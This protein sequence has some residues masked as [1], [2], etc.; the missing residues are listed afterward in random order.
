MNELLKSNSKAIVH[1]RQQ[2]KCRRLGLVFGAGI[3]KDLDFPNWSDLVKGIAEHEDVDGGV[4][5]KNDSKWSSSTSITQLLFQHFKSTRM[6]VLE[7]QYPSVAY[8]ERHVK[9]DWRE[10][11]HSVLYRSAL[12]SRFDK[13]K[14]HPYLINFIPLINGSEFSVNYN[15]DDTLEYMLSIQKWNQR[16][17]KGRP[18][19]SV[20][21]PHMQFRENTAVIY[22]PN[23]YL[24]GDKNLQQSDELVFSEESFSDQ[25]LESMSGKLST[26]LHM[27]TKK[28]CLLVGLSLQDNTLKH[29]LRQSSVI[30]PG[31]FHYFIRYTSNRDTLT[32][33]EKNA[34]FNSNF[35]VYNLITLFLD[36]EEISN[37]AELVS[38]DTEEF[39]N[40]ANIAGVDTN[41]NYYLVGTVGAG[42]STI[43]DH[44]GNLKLY[45]EWLEE[46]PHDLAKPFSQL[47]SDEKERVDE[48][49]NSQFFKKNLKLL[50]EKEGIHLID[51]TPLDPITFS[52]DDESMKLRAASMLKIIS[53]GNSNYQI[54][55]GH[56]LLVR[57]TPKELKNRL[58]SKRKTEWSEDD[59]ALLQERALK[60]YD[61]FG[62]KAI[63]NIGRTIPEIVK[64]V[65]RII[66]IE[67]YQPT[68][69]HLKLQE[70]AES[71]TP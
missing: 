7:A 67:D 30:S 35:E 33:N 12:E 64:E 40:L 47:T 2:Y 20:W 34:I 21:N 11:V 61:S 5:Y 51:R 15:F 39:V 42:K 19:Q 44:F 4:I 26:L 17:S 43:L 22:H 6:A 57:S 28:T 27:F 9:A 25:L 59:I 1:L 60:I 13:V 8:R 18:Y 70:V 24:P 46:R 56:V 49:V 54:S 32:D 14:N 48:W 66:H 10:I 58:L 29:L 65:A 38:M 31:N 62:L 53:P 69:L 37:L 55:L 41:Y 3:S 68:N 23:G 71:E 50:S 16:E 36:S 45:E 52:P 63:D